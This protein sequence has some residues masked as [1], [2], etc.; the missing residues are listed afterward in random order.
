MQTNKLLLKFAFLVLIITTQ[1]LLCFKKFSLW[2]FSR[3]L[4]P[5]E[6]GLSPREICGRD[7][8]SAAD[9]FKKR[10]DQEFKERMR[11]SSYP[12][13]MPD[14]VI[15]NRTL[16]A[17]IQALPLSKFFTDSQRPLYHNT[18]QVSTI[19]ALNSTMMKD[20]DLAYRA[21]V[22]DGSRLKPTAPNTV[23]IRQ[24]LPQNGFCVPG[25]KEPFFSKFYFDF[26]CFR[27]P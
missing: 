6:I 20:L 14:E 19:A 5:K 3:G 26:S 9:E 8:K 22:I 7:L 1:S 11:K 16:F 13:P 15:S 18:C 4:P 23:R 25:R 24:N 27:K 12:I 21:R 2:P 10:R 17:E